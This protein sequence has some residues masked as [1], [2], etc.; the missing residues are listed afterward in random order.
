VQVG[1]DL[2]VLQLGVLREGVSQLHGVLRLLMVA[3]EYA[4]DV[5]A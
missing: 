1:T 2:Q 5:E 3:R 4:A